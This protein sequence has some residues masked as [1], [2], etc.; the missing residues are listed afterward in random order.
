MSLDFSL[1]RDV[2]GVLWL[3]A[4]KETKSGDLEDRFRFP[5]KKPQKI[6]LIDTWLDVFLADEKTSSGYTTI[7]VY[8]ND[9]EHFLETLFPKQTPQGPYR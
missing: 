6:E 1:E 3:V 9:R 8:E 2:I 5:V 7:R 4:K